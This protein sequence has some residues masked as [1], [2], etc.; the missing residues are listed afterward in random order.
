MTGMIKMNRT[1]EAV[2]TFLMAG[3]VIFAALSPILTQFTNWSI[4]PFYLSLLILG[5]AFL[6]QG[7]QKNFREILVNPANLAMFCFIAVLVYVVETAEGLETILGAILLPYGLGLIYAYTKSEDMRFENYL[8]LLLALKALLILFFLDDLLSEYPV[9][10]QFEGRAIYL[11]F[12]WA[13]DVAPFLVTYYLLVKQK[14]STVNM[15]QVMIFMFVFAFVIVSMVSRTMIILS[16]AFTAIFSFLYLRDVK[17]KLFGIFFYPVVVLVLLLMFPVKQQHLLGM[18]TTLTGMTDIALFSDNSLIDK[19]TTIRMQGILDTF[20][21][22][23]TSTAGHQLDLSSKKF[24]W[25]GHFWIG[26]IKYYTGYVGLLLFMT[27]IFCF[28]WGL[29]Q[30]SQRMKYERQFASVTLI[31]VSVSYLFHIFYVGGILNGPIFFLLLGLVVNLKIPK[32]S[33]EFPY[34]YHRSDRAESSFQ[35]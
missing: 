7:S 30:L 18:F 25:A 14:A 2:I 35:V 33:V 32:D 3:F 8:L 9:R 6:L 4:Y 12:G 15:A 20:F 13:L 17:I 28:M 19:S 16:L 1:V 31:A 29:Y 10:P 23:E 22:K 21:T 24:Y 34:E 5:N 26:Q 27:L 11:Q